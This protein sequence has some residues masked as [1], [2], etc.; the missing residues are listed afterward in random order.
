MAIEFTRVHVNQVMWLEDTNEAEEKAG[1]TKK[2]HNTLMELLY[3][4]K[5]HASLT[6]TVC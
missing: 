3:T 6:N 2:W 4:R 5:D 1:L